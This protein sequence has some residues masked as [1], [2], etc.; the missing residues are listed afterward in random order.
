LKCLLV[1]LF[2]PALCAQLYGLSKTR[3]AES[4]SSGLVNYVKY[5]SRI[6]SKTSKEEIM[7]TTTNASLGALRLTASHISRLLYRKGRGKQYLLRASNMHMK[8]RNK[9]FG[10]IMGIMAFQLAILAL[11]RAE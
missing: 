7:E 10:R 5:P 3:L 11:K 6:T 1:S 8:R 9:F 4:F 2:L